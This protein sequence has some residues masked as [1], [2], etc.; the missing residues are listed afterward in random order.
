MNDRFSFDPANRTL[1]IVPVSWVN[2]VYI[3]GDRRQ[4][5]KTTFAQLPEQSKFTYSVYLEAAGHV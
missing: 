1:R 3:A 5:L 4:N 2:L